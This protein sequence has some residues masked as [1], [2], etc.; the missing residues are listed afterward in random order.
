MDQFASF[1][2]LVIYDGNLTLSQRK[3]YLLNFHAFKTS[4]KKLIIQDDDA[5]EKADVDCEQPRET[6][7]QIQLLIIRERGDLPAVG[8][9]EMQARTYEE[10]FMENVRNLGPVRQ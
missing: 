7:E 1:I 4:V 8:E 10:L 6:D 3:R 9:P 5:A 2:H